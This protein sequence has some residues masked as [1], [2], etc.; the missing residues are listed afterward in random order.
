MIN[1]HGTAFYKRC[2]EAVV[3]IMTKTYSS[4]VSADIKYG[5]NECGENVGASVRNH[6][7]THAW[8]GEVV[9]ASP[10]GICLE[11][12]G[13]AMAAPP[14]FLWASNIAAGGILLVTKARYNEASDDYAKF[15]LDA[16]R[17]PTLV[18]V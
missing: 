11:Q 3:G 9:G 8:E 10:A 13:S 1:D 12:V 5:T 18:A 15:S 7:A 4:E 6:K 14:T 17:S 16:E 2:A